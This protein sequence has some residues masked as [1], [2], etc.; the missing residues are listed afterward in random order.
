MI[1]VAGRPFSGASIAGSY[2]PDSVEAMVLKAMR[3]SGYQYKFESNQAL[4]FE[5]RL[6]A[7]IVNAARQLHKSG[8]GFAVFARTRCS[9]KYWNRENNGGFRLKR[10]AVPAAAIRDIY[11]NGRA[12]ATECATA[13]MIV[14]YKAFL[15]L[16]GD[17]KFNSLFDEIYLMNW[18]TTDPLLRAV[19]TPKPVAEILLGDRG[20]FA[21]PDVD[22]QTP[23]WQGEN[24][25]VM[26]DN[27]YYGHGVGIQTS[28]RIISSL[29]RNRKRGAA[30][31]AYMMSSAGRPDFNKLAQHDTAAVREPAQTWRIPERVMQ[32]G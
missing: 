14:Y 2:S 15:E 1:L 21:N 13:M 3:D 12:Y 27:L 17:A 26:P 23:Q 18:H 9:D 24:V 29:N 4:S 6:R 22:P 32:G 7:E 19:S 10:D 5:L 11:S 25:I 20:Y 8:L 28:E 16:Y 30:R 31:S